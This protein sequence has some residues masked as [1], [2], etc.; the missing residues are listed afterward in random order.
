MLELEVPVMA[1]PV[2]RI[3]AVLESGKGRTVLTS[4]T[5]LPRGYVI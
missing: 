2:P 5:P 1:D 4:F 3:E